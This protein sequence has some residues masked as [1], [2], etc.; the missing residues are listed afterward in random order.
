MIES[1][2]AV[3]S[4]A[5]KSPITTDERRQIISLYDEVEFYGATRAD[6]STADVNA[7]WFSQWYLQNLNALYTGPLD[8]P[9]WRSLNGKSLIASRLYEFLF[10]KFYGGREFLRF[11][12]STLVK[13][14]PVRT[15]RY[16]SQAQK[17]LQPALSLLMEHGVLQDVQWV[18][19]RSG[20]PQLVLRRGPVLST[21]AGQMIADDIDEEA[22]ALKKVEPVTP[23]VTIVR[24]YHRLWGHGNY[25]PSKSEIDTART[26]RV[27]LG[28]A[29]LME[30]LP[31]VVKRMRVKF[32]DAKT[33]GAATLYIDEIVKEQ[34]QRRLAD[35]RARQ[36][37]EQREHERAKALEHAQQQEI[38]KAA[39]MTLSQDE[40]EDIRQLV[41]RGQPAT[42]AKHHA[43]VERLCLAEL[44]KRFTA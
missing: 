28:D 19:G 4:A 16:L 26:F 15:E 20:D 14:I 41:L 29:Q 12:Y 22:F 31:A 24:E 5:E 42:L 39:W 17:Q 7:V 10:L 34:E 23:E 18:A 1:R 37:E 40:R 32:P 38:L 33:F 3:F 30:M 44:A 13:F 11:N 27:R 43:L 25:K 35:E 8:Y 2:A 36:E 9:L 6:G 21:V